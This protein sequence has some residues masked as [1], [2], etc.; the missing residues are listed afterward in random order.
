MPALPDSPDI[1]AAPDGPGRLFVI[2]GAPASGK[3]TVGRALAEALTKSIFVDGEVMADMVAAGR[4]PMTAEPTIGA[5][6][7]LFTRYAGALTLADVYCA[8]GFDTVIA[9][10]MVG[11]YLEDFLDLADTGPLHLIVLHPSVDAVHERELARGV[12]AYGDGSATEN[13]WNE[14]EFNTKRVGLWI[15]NSTLTPAQ[16]VVRILRNLD[17]ATVAPP[18]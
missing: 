5:L 16:V 8:N 17:E 12:N 10:N 3:S 11:D 1:P 4:T 2:T 13:V 15:D 9:D 14:V 6:E 7:Q 18:D